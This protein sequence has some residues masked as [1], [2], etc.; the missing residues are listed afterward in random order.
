MSYDTDTANNYSAQLRE[1][2][3]QNDQNS[4]TQ[5]QWDFVKQ[6]IETTVSKT[7]EEIQKQKTT[8][9]LWNKEVKDLSENQKDLRIQ[10]RNC[11]Q[12]EKIKELKKE[13]NYVLHKIRRK[14]R[15][16]KEKHLD[17]LIQEID[18]SKTDGGMFKAIKVLNR[19]QFTNPQVNDK[20]GKT[21]TSP[22]EIQNT[23][24][25]H[26]KAKFRD[27]CT[28]NDELNHLVGNLVHLTT[29]SVKKK[30]DKA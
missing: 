12:E 24:T 18:N 15:E 5:K 8:Y 11:K 17:H 3:L 22:T 10:I 1:L 29:Q 28:T 9:R 27:E 14:N 26:F 4:S 20:E 30:L 25:K 23:I 19:K 6:A 21:V 7:I 16:T 2:L 13:R